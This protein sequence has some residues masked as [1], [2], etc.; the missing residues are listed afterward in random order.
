MRANSF[1]R[2]ITDRGRRRDD[3]D[4]N[5]LLSIVLI[6]SVVYARY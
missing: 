1:R 2:R 3:D 6:D 5:L 4:H